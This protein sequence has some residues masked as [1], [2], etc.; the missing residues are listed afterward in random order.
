MWQD[1]D[2]MEEISTLENENEAHPFT[3]QFTTSFVEKNLDRKQCRPNHFFWATNICFVSPIFIF[4]ILITLWM[5][6]K[7]ISYGVS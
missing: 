1:K 2:N 7:T 6:F 4:V 3:F 5:H